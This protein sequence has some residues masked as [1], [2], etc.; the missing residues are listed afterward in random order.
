MITSLLEILGVGNREEGKLILAD[1]QHTIHRT[2]SIDRPPQT[3]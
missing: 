3:I 1:T 2:R